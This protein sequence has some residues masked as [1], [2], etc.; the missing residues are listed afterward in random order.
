MPYMKSSH[1]GYT[2]L[3]QSLMHSNYA[4]DTAYILTRIMLKL[5]NIC[6]FW[7]HLKAKNTLFGG[8]ITYS[9][10][11]LFLNLTMFL[12]LVG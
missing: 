3:Y 7:K 11:N 9:V 2:V 12:A 1:G 8:K 5:I 4:G 10:L 6:A